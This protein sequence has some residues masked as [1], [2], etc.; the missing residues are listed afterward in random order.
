MIFRRLLHSARFCGVV[1]L[2][3]GG[4]TLA[5][6][7]T[8]I[9]TV[10]ELQAIQNNL[11]GSYA[12]AADIN[13][14]A[15][16]TWNDGAGFLPIGNAST[17][18]SGSFNGNGHVISGLYINSTAGQVGLFGQIGSANGHT[19]VVQNV[20]MTGGSITAYSTDYAYVGSLA[21]ANAGT[22]SSS[23]S[24]TAITGGQYLDDSTGGLVGYNS[25]SI[26]NSHATGKVSGAD[27]GGLVGDNFGIIVQCY[28]TGTV[29][30]GSGGYRGS[31]GL[32]GGN[33]S[34]I[35]SSYANGSV[36]GDFGRIGGLVG[37]N[38]GG[39]V[40][41]SYARGAVTGTDGVYVGGLVGEN[42][43]SV[44]TSVSTGKVS[45]SGTFTAGG[46]IGIMDSGGSVTSSYWDIQASGQT[47]SGGGAGE[48]TAQLTSGLPAG[49]SAQV[50]DIVVRASY[51]YLPLT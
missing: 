13:A 2:S 3:F 1:A 18:F 27:Q 8:Q 29:S 49:F 44:V 51:P 16:S 26:F 6:A 10:E 17:P 33:Y 25:G 34:S 15:T 7:T 20:G 32:V 45:G 46:L 48:T 42:N 30:G 38:E 11:S 28:A 41:N 40:T 14:S 19:G 50:W 31:G 35:E 39:S 21:G 4:I 23:Y 22:I 37:F 5:N 24:S 12:L 36:T 43:G 9:T 47:S